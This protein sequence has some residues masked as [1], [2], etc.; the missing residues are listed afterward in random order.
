M[1]DIVVYSFHTAD[2]YYCEKGQE[3]RESLQKLGV[4]FQIDEIEI[5]EGKTWADLCREKISMLYNFCIAH[6]GKKVFWIDADCILSELPKFVA[7]FSADIIGFQRG[8]GDPQKIG[9]NFK[10]RFWEPCMIGINCTS[11]GRQ[12]IKDAYLIE[13]EFE[14]MATDDYF[15]EESWR[16]NCTSMS[17][18]IIPS[19]Y[20]YLPGRRRKA[21][22]GITP[23][24]H[25]GASGNVKE[26]KGKVIQHKR[27]NE[28]DATIL[29]ILTRDIPRRIY[30]RLRSY[31]ARILPNKIREKLA[32][33][34]SLNDRANNKFLKIKAINSAIAGDGV[35]I[36]KLLESRGGESNLSMQQGAII[37]QARS[38]LSY[39]GTNAP[40]PGLIDLA[41]WINPEPGNFGDWLSPY[42][43]N[44]ISG[45]NVRYVNPQRQRV[46]EAH[47]FS[48][49]SIGK[50]LKS[51]SIVMGTGVSAVDA[52]L[53]PNARYRSVRG[54]RTHSLVKAAGGDCPEL[55]GD[56]AI[57]MPL[58]YQAKAVQKTNKIGLVRHFTHKSIPISLPDNVEELDILCSAPA[59]LESFIDKLHEYDYVLSSAMHAYII[60]QAYG[61]PCG[62][63]NFEGAEA[64]VHGDGLKYHDYFEGVSL[65]SRMPTVIPGNLRGRDLSLLVS[66][67][68]ISRKVILDL[69][70]MFKD[71]LILLGGTQ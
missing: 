51:S 33:K 35:A 55:F 56:P 11:G 60:C 36:E 20:A 53:N 41:W 69:E 68:D 44:K 30:A 27:L 1:K 47:Y 9:Y 49:G 64:S 2:K 67:E 66:K 16:K 4:Q 19:S 46:Q 39:R 70:S 59:E 31:L 23:F 6:E 25:F 52:V 54:P 10:A 65:P 50:F 22:E 43:F 40:G 12:F 42:I 3:L 37:H 18:Q 62:L 8:F 57:L 5:P 17:F 63:I 29:A 38:V 28:D 26:F 34:Q 45:R 24:F 7:D 21:A 32:G 14:G 48:V 15:F 13:R 71:E 58:L 61:I